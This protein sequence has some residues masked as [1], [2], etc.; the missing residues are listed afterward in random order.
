MLRVTDLSTGY[1]ENKIL[2]GVSVEINQG[3]IAGLV[4]SNAAGKTTLLHTISGVNK[5]WSGKI[6]FMGRDITKM[7]SQNRTEMGLIQC[8]EG[9]KLFPSLNVLENLLLGSYSKRSKKNKKKMMENVYEMFPILY[10]RRYQPAG[11]LSGGEQQM[12]AIGRALMG[13]PEL[14]IMDEPSLGLAPIIVQKVFEIIEQINRTGVT[15]FLVEQNVR[16]ALSLS[17]HAYAMENGRIT[18]H[19]AGQELL[20]DANLRKTY[21][22]I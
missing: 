21:L 11:L 14:L 12:C 19:G 15:I 9:R 3:E 5:V 7:S 10:E 22:G 13:D 18:M 20:Q 2:F 1:G 6:E 4:G 8:P 16:K 17:T